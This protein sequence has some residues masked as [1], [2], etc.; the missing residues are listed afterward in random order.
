[1]NELAAFF[2]CLLKRSKVLNDN[3]R[4]EVRAGFGLFNFDDQ[5]RVCLIQLV[6]GNYQR[7]HKFS[8]LDERVAED[9]ECA[10]S[11]NTRLFE[12]DT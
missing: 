11:P 10:L 12:F 5:I 8:H 7:V 6:K 4:K 2:N 9:P 3:R 1:M